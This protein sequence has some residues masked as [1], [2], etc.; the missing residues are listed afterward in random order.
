MLRFDSEFVYFS[1]P[2]IG[3]VSGFKPWFI[4]VHHATIIFYIGII[5]CSKAPRLFCVSRHFHFHSIIKTTVGVI[6]YNTNLCRLLHFLW[7]RA[8]VFMFMGRMFGVPMSVHGV[9]KSV[10]GCSRSI[11]LSLMCTQVCFWVLK[12]SLGIFWCH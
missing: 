11:L 7:I 6:G 2:Q 12:V 8:L 10:F 4:C 1:F 3:Q 9:P 5:M